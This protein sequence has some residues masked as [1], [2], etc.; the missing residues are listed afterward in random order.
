MK[1]RRPQ[2]APRLAV[3]DGESGDH[4]RI[5]RLSARPEVDADDL[6][7]RGV[8][9]PQAVSRRIAGLGRNVGAAPRLDEQRTLKC[10]DDLPV[11]VFAYGVFRAGI[12][13]EDLVE[14]VDHE[15][16]AAEERRTLRELRWFRTWNR[17]HV[18]DRRT[19]ALHVG[20]VVE[21]ADDQIA[22]LQNAFAERL[23]RDV[24]EAVRIHVSVQRIDRRADR[25]LRREQF[26]NRRMIGCGLHSIGSRILHLV[27]SRTPHLIGSRARHLIGSSGHARASRRHRLIGSGGVASAGDKHQCSREDQSCMRMRRASSSRSANLPTNSTPLNVAFIINQNHYQLLLPIVILRELRETPLWPKAKRSRRKKKSTGAA[28]APV[29][30][31]SS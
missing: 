10:L 15:R 9:D 2:N 14:R 30:P 25:L 7:A 24:D 4:G 12:G 26:Q 23:G 1:A 28:C 20:F 21:V 11:R 13:R 22:F 16:R 19:G 29:H 27:G 6:T 3:I 5:R 18:V 31:M 8:G 17:R